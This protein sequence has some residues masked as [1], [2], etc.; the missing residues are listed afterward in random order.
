[1]VRTGLFILILFSLIPKENRAQSYS[2]APL[3]GSPFLEDTYVKG[4]VYQRDHSFET[5][6]RYNIFADRME[7]RRLGSVEFLTPAMAV[8]KIVIKTNTFVADQYLLKGQLTY[9]YFILL[10]SGKIRILKKMN[11]AITPFVPAAPLQDTKPAMY[12]RKADTYYLKIDNQTLLEIRSI[13]KL[14]LSLPDHQKEME[15]FAKKERI[16]ANEPEDLVKFSR[17]YNAL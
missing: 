7:F 10:D 13:K 5:D 6:L 2:N 8:T 16:S 15:A 11:I 12:T 4:T 9:G 14:I 1:M 3:E 17:Y